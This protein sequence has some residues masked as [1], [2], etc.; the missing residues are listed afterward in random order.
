MNN[1]LDTGTVKTISGTIGGIVKEV[2]VKP[3]MIAIT[4]G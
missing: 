1:T 2:Y 3:V 4:I